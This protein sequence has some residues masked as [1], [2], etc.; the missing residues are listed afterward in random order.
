MSVPPTMSDML[1][2]Y[3]FINYYCL[4]HGVDFYL[5]NC[6]QIDLFIYTKMLFFYL[7][8]IRMSINMQY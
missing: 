1:F 3:C 8:Y 6:D 5:T 2:I 7:F 4:L